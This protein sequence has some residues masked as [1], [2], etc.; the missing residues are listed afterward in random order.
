MTPS[1]IRLY[2]VLL[3]SLPWYVACKQPSPISYQAAHQ[4]CL[5]AQQ[6]LWDQNGGK[7]VRFPWD[8]LM[9]SA[10]PDSI[11]YTVTG[12]LI[13][14]TFY[15]NKITLVNFWF[16]TCPPCVEEIPYLNQLVDQF[17]HDQFNYLGV[18]NV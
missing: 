2:L 3:I 13:D 17:G 18:G 9:G 7:F 11:G 8:C 12:K 4:A 16:E 14:P 6:K 5:E 10:M 1:R 15:K